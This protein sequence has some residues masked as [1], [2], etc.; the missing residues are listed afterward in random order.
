MESCLTGCPIFSRSLY[1]P[2]LKILYTDNHLLVVDKP[3]GIATMG[4]EAGVP[5]IARQ[6]AEY[7]QRVG[8]KPGKA[9]IGVVSRLDRLVSGVLVLAR[10]SKAASRLSEQ[11]RQQT[12]GKYYLALV[13]GTWP[14]TQQVAGATSPAEEWEALQDWVIKD[15]GAQR[16]RVTH[17]NHPGAQ[18]AKLRVQLIASARDQSLVRIELLTGRKHQIRLQLA[19]HG[20][21]IVGD[22]KYG[23]HHKFS[24]GIALHCQQVTILHPTLK[25]PMVFSSSPSSHWSQLPS[26]F[27]HLLST[28]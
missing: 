12:T 28:D 22:A 11:I 20:M 6:A 25:Q 14:R 26:A 23:A 10:T 24:P 18:L 1:V 8:N 7:L 3:A 9:F 5:T 17:P 2:A 15:E 21:P 19:E 16:M 13:E 27:R 4:S